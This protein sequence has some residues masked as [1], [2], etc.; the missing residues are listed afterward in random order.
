M[1]LWEFSARSMACARGALGYQ[2]N[3]MWLDTFA[4]LPLV[5][6]GMVR[7]LREK[8]V[9]LYTLTLFLSVFANYYIGF[10]TCIF[11]FLTFFCYEICRW[12]GW[13]RFFAD[14]IRIGIFSVLAIGMSAILSL[15]ALA[16]LQTTQSSVNKFPT[17]FRLNIASTHDFLGLLDGMRQ[18]AGNLGGGISPTFKEGLPNIYCGVG[19]LLLAILYLFSKEIRLREKLCAVF[20]L[21]FFTVSFLIRQLD[22]IWHGFHF[23]NMIP[24][25]FSFLMSFVL[26]YMGLSGMAGAGQAV[27]AA[28]CA[29][30]C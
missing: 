28:D 3:M 13:K 6:L 20:L 4:L 21:L 18:V 27:P 1:R 16:A 8:R 29:A 17:G 30:G 11:V 5:A 14:F 9:V 23:P 22:Y 19:T 12:R 24:Y 25:R 15:T 26:L 10:F 7:L 2:W